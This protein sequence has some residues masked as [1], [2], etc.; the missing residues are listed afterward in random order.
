MKKIL[1]ITNH[2]YMFYQFRRDLVLDL[3]KDGYQVTLCTPFNGHQEDFVSF[4]CK[5][6][7]TP[8]ERRGINPKQEM[9]LYQNYV[10]ILETMANYASVCKNAWELTAKVREALGLQICM[11]YADPADKKLRVMSL[12][13]P[14]TQLIADHA[15]YP[16]DGSKP[17]PSLDPVDR[18]KWIK[19]LSSSLAKF[20]TLG[21]LPIILTVSPVRQ[22]VRASIEREQPGVVVLSDMEVYE[23]GNN[24][25]VEIIDE[26]KGEDE[27]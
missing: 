5:V 19:A 14:L 15:Y 4:G 26:I 23:A 11:Q 22:L 10:K 27:Q 8:L 21:Y 20:N 7:E 17:T 2:S 12:S 3:L 1:F 18:R 24:V 9:E 13:Q 6:I 25:S 16:P